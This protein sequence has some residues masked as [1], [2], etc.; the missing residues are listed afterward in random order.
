VAREMT[1]FL[2]ILSDAQYN[3]YYFAIPLFLTG[4]MCCYQVIIFASSANVV[5][6]QL[7]GVTAHS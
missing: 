4:I 3:W 5:K 7:L 2:F 6:P 1:V